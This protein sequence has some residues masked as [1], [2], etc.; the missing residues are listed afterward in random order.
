MTLEE[1]I[2]KI[3]TGYKASQELIEYAISSDTNLFKDRIYYMKAKKV[4]EEDFF[5]SIGYN[6]GIFMSLFKYNGRTRKILEL[7]QKARKD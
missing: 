6:Y 7:H 1:R 2:N 3:K 4:I 5:K